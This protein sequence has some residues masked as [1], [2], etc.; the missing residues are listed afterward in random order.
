[1]TRAA[2]TQFT[3][4][5]DVD[6]AYQVLGDG[7]RDIVMTM[8]WVTYLEVMWELPELAYFLERLAG[9]GRVIIFD[10]RGTGLSDRVPG[11]VTLEQRAEDVRAV[12]DAAQSERAAYIGWARPRSRSRES[13]AGGRALHSGGVGPCRAQRA[14][15]L[16]DD[17]GRPAGRA[18]HGQDAV[19]RTQPPLD[20]GQAAAPG[21]VG[22]AAAVVGDLDP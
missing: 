14:R 6:I 19:E 7:E 4:S 2:E 13:P 10:K 8:G 21:R 17:H 3:R 5:D 15:Y 22:A 16:H 11:M 20:P 18:A 12:M 9:M 1:M